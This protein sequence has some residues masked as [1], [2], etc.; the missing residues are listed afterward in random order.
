M[1]SSPVR[2]HHVVSTQWFR[3][4][5]PTVQPSGVR[6]SG[7]HPS[8]VQSAA[9]RLRRS[10]RAS[11]SLVP[12]QAAAVATR[13]RR[14]AIVTTQA[15]RVPVGCRVLERLDKPA[16][17]ARARAMLPRSHWSVGSVADPGQV[18]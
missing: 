13:S 2:V 4:P 16:E 5:G 18:G 14:R 9:V 10:G 6:P 1:A 15:G 7:V 3:R 8:G 12:P 11:I 17:Q